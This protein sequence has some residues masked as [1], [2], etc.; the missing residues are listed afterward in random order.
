MLPQLLPRA[1][2]WAEAQSRNICFLRGDPLSAPR[3][4]LARAVGVVRPELIRIWNVPEIPAPDDPQLRHFA[5]EQNLIG[6]GTHA[7]TLGYGILILHGHADSQLLL[8]EFRHVHQYE[9]AGSIA[10]F[11]PVYLKQIADYGYHDA[12]YEVDARAHEHDKYPDI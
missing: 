9:A 5:R 10:A 4:A 6:P 2:A 12:P 7:L 11:L 1:I 3:L 8:H